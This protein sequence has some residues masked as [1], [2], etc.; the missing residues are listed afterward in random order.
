MLK[1]FLEY[2]KTSRTLTPE[3]EQELSF[4]IEGAMKL[5]VQFGVKAVT[6]D[7]VSKSLGMSKKT[8]YKHFCNKAD[9]VEKTF[10]SVQDKVQLSVLDIFHED[11]GNAIDQLVNFDAFADQH[12]TKDM[13]LLL[14]QVVMY[15]PEVAQKLNARRAE[16]ATKIVV[17]NLKQGIEEGLYRA[18]MNI[19][20]ITILY[21]GHLVAAHQTMINP[22]GI[23]EHELRKTSFRYHLRGIVSE[24]GLEYFNQ[25]IKN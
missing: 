15:Y 25:H 16:F 9:L 23:D 20:H 5:F 24:Q 10:G 21:L 2:C 19:E 1:S 22:N 3:L 11:A 7:Q 8:L 6:M 12:F 14:N 18:D 13:E 17:L 4:I